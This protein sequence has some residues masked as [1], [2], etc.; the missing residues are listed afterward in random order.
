VGSGLLAA[1]LEGLALLRRLARLAQQTLAAE[2]VAVF[3]IPAQ[4]LAAQALSVSGGLNKE[5]K[6]ELCTHQQ[7][8]S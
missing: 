4:V 7:Q 2:G 5:N 8:H 6:N 3:K 1:A